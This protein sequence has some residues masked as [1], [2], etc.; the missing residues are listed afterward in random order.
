VIHRAWD[1]L[2]NKQFG[3]K[4]VRAWRSRWWVQAAG[5]VLTFNAVSFSFVFFLLDAGTALRVLGQVIWP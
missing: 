1:A 2:L 3:R 5:I 4:S